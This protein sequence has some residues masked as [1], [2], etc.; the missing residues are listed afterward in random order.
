MAKVFA[1][2]LVQLISL[3]D[4]NSRPNALLVWRYAAIRGFF[5]SFDI[6]KVRSA[7]HWSSS[8]LFVQRYLLHWIPDARCVDMGSAPTV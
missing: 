2:R 1:G 3:A 6:D 5:R 7:D 8:T 4:P